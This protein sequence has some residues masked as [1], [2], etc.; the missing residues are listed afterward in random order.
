MDWQ[1]YATLCL[2]P[3]GRVPIFILT[4]STYIYINIVYPS[5]A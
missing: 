1:I 3:F 2:R 5:S 4:T